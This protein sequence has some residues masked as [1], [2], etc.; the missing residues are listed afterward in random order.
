MK[1][2]YDRPI[3]GWEEAR[4][5]WVP[6]ARFDPRLDNPWYQALPV[7]NGR[8]GGMV[9]GGVGWERIQLNEETLRSGGP[10]D[11]S[12]PQALALLPEVRRLIFA[13]RYA[14]AGQ[15]VHTRLLGARGDPSP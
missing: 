8:L 15:L 6:A 3:A 2:W 9:F 10:Q 13:G 14:E 12:N 5:A 4:T 7:G 11:R 1:L